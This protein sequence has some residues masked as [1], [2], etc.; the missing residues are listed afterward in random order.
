[1]K[2]QTVLLSTNRLILQ[3]TLLYITATIYDLGHPSQFFPKTNN[4]KS[5]RV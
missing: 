2:A 5:I 1:M 4:W 3:E